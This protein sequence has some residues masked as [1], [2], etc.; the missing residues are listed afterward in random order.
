MTQDEWATKEST[1]FAPGCLIFCLEPMA[2]PSGLSSFSKKGEEAGETYRV[3][4]LCVVVSKEDGKCMVVNI[5]AS[6]YEFRTLDSLMV[7]K[8][9]KSIL[10]GRDFH[11]VAARPTKKLDRTEEKSL[12]EVASSYAQGG[13]RRSLTVEGSALAEPAFAMLAHLGANLNTVNPQA[14]KTVLDI[15]LICHMIVTPE[16]RQ[17]DKTKALLKVTF[18]PIKAEDLEQLANPSQ[19]PAPVAGVYSE[20]PAAMFYGQGADLGALVSQD[21]GEIA[22]PLPGAFAPEPQYEALPIAEPEQVFQPAPLFQPIL[23]AQPL[24]APLVE[25]APEP[26]VMEPVPTYQPAPAP[27]AEVPA[28]VP[29]YEPAPAMVAPPQAPGPS[30]SGTGLRAL[31]QQAQP[32]SD[33]IAQEWFVLSQDL[34]PI[35]TL[36]STSPKSS[37]LIDVL[38]APLE[39]ASKIDFAAQFL[40]DFQSG[41]AGSEAIE[42]AEKQLAEERRRTEELEKGKEKRLKEYFGDDHYNTFIKDSVEAGAKPE[43]SS[44]NWD[45]DPNAYAQPAPIEAH[46]ESDIFASG[47]RGTLETN[48]EAI[49]PEPVAPEPIIAPVAET[50][51]EPEAPTARASNQAPELPDSWMSLAQPQAAAEPPAAVAPATESR[52]NISERDIETVAPSSVAHFMD[53]AAKDIASQ[54]ETISIADSGALLE[55]PQKA[56][57]A[58]IHA[59]DEDIDSKIE[60][61]LP[62]V[63]PRDYSSPLRA[64]SLS[65]LQNKRPMQTPRQLS[66]AEALN[67]ELAAATTSSTSLPE[68]TAPAASTSSTSLPEVP[69]QAATASSTSLPQVSSQTEPVADA[70][71]RQATVSST[72]L[73]QM[74]APAASPSTSSTGLPAQ[75]AA[76]VATPST[77]STSLPAQDAA[78]LAS[79]STS[80]TGLP[81]Q[82]PAVTG[83][84]VSATDLPA[85]ETVATGPSI[86]STDLPAQATAPSATP[87]TSSTGL[88]AQAPQDPVGPSISSTDLPAQTPAKPWVSATKLPAQTQ[89]PPAASTSSTNLPAQTEPKPWQSA[90]NLPAQSTAPAASTSATNL[91][92][93]PANPKVSSTNLTPP[94]PAQTSP[95]KSWQ[96]LP[97]VAP[98]ESLTQPAPQPEVLQTKPAIPA[99]ESAS[100]SATRLP[101]QSA[102]AKLSAE[103]SEAQSK[104]AGQ[105][106]RLMMNE[107]TTL[108]A[109][110]EQ[111][112]GKAANK[113]SS[114]AEELK[115]RLRGQVDDLLKQASEIEKQAEGNL[116]VLL[117]ELESKLQFLAEEVNGTIERES[118]AAYS[119]M[120]EE[121]QKGFEELEK[122]QKHFSG[123]IVR[124]CNDFRKELDALSASMESKLEDLITARNRELTSLRQSILDELKDGHE[125]YNTTVDQRFARFKE[126]MDEETDTVTR[127]LERNMRSMI[128]EIDSSLER[129]CEKL[130]GTKLDLEKTIAH[131]VAFAEMTIA[132][133]TK[134]ILSEQILPRL[135]E[136]KTILRTMIGD[137]SKQINQETTLALSKESTK[138]DDST[139]KASAS[140]KKVVEECFQ[141]FESSGS[142]LRAGL[143]DTFAKA[144]HELNQRISEVHNYIKETEK[145]ISESDLTLRNLAEATNVDGEPELQEERANALSTLQRL[146]YEAN[147]KLTSAIEDGITG[148]EDKSEKYFSELTNKRSELTSSVR[149]C[150]ESNLDMVRQALQEATASIQS[151]REKHMD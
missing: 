32:P 18:A 151:A 91:P 90:S 87:S 49:L 28:P 75:D 64:K 113:L 104:K 96:S 125:R 7:E 11:Y 79:P 112:V 57:E 140:L 35:G 66:S 127:S 94:V 132:R 44:D 48:P 5:T 139:R 116:S 88:P 131:T 42:Q 23:A 100:T 71:A 3:K 121:R 72:S 147:R 109:K 107:M 148:L 129:A 27:M 111:Q 102:A 53:M 51:V 73:P 62:R 21:T 120:E 13:S 108:M 136:Q 130:E 98:A 50:I 14:G 89:T 134:N 115:L 52:P 31:T 133:R 22:A 17:E 142:G 106:A 38:S 86:S 69:A 119:H 10:D 30:A 70:P 95:K 39:P 97:A 149:D 68:V 83:P 29:T 123:Q 144:S 33:M 145:R 92:A 47:G 1:L 124:T 60:T 19:P 34:V 25:A 78:P 84:S 58:Q 15:G 93:Q 54:D 45:L 126:R 46:Y 2:A 55:P 81:A 74:S 99:P 76:P 56:A 8:A 12:Y 122:E 26:P 146:K 114:R 37:G 138:L 101:A 110:L 43:G 82:A 40:S 24:T 128:E 16:G 9:R 67:P 143:D 59:A 6:A 65:E 85:Q 150:A 61:P 4:D 63:R 36:A 135:N 20:D 103:E 77:S 141:N 41:H 105:D 137:M 118:T 80:S 117:N